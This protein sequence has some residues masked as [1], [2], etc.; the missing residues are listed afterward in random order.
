MY[1]RAEIAK[2][3]VYAIL[4]MGWLETAS[5][6]DFASRADDL[7]RRQTGNTCPLSA[8]F[9][10]G[11]FMGKFENILLVSGGQRN[12]GKT[13]FICNLISSHKEKNVI[14]VKITPHF[15]ES[16][17]GLETIKTGKGWI[18][19]KESNREQK[20]DTSLYLIAGAKESFFL[21]SEKETLHE[22]FDALLSYLPQNAPVIIESAGL[23]EI[24]KPQLFVVILPDNRT[25]KK[26]MENKL[27]LTDLIVISDGKKFYP[28]TEI[29]TFHNKWILR[30]PK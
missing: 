11:F 30:T 10:R 28:S 29:V 8:F 26:E 1:I 19:S 20:K 24:I 2:Y 25:I 5:P 18:L 12:V 3:L 6:P 27:L 7:E 21:Q 14:A 15:H 9:E 4:P 22:A 16:T 23:I 13:T 17:S